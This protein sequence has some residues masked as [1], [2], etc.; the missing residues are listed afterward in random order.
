M[1]DL[2]SK[3]T[4]LLFPGPRKWMYYEFFYSTYDRQFFLYNDFN[5]LLIEMNIRVYKCTAEML[6]G[7]E[8][9]NDA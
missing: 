1:N 5:E 6:M 7:V 8:D 2:Y 3:Y 9:E 4:K